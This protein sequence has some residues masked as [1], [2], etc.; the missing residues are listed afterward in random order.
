M[1]D[2]YECYLSA[3][4]RGAVRLICRAGEYENLPKEAYRGGPWA[5]DRAG[6]IV[7]LKP[8]YR[9]ALARQGYVRVEGISGAFSPEVRSGDSA[10]P[11]ANDPQG[12]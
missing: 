3:R 10:P 5:S 8:E 7:N 6:Q 2:S 11:R 1:T 9:L 12:S 4:P